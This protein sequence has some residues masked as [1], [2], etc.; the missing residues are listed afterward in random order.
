MFVATAGKHRIL[1]FDKAIANDI[2]V[3]VVENGLFAADRERQ[4][5]RWAGVRQSP[6]FRA[7]PAPMVVCRQL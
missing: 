1:R 2:A 4:P 3:L 6:S 7:K 5:S